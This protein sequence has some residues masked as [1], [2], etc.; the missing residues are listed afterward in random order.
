MANKI[1]TFLDT[2]PPNSDGKSFNSSVQALS[3]LN[4]RMS[5]V[6][7]A[8]S[9]AGAGKGAKV[10]YGNP[11]L[12]RQPAP[13]VIILIDDPR[14]LAGINGSHITA[15]QNSMVIVAHGGAPKNRSALQSALKEQ[16]RANEDIPG[17]GSKYD[18]EFTSLQS[19][20]CVNATVEQ[21]IN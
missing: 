6:S 20:R 18:D 21:C 10:T 3:V 12:S 7:H 5:R 16:G 1:Q 4:V 19:G 8:L 15:P 13:N 14:D 9:L 17:A 11:K 2:R